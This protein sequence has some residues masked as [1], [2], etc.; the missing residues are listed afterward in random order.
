MMQRAEEARRVMQEKAFKSYR[1]ATEDDVR[2][3]HNY[4]REA[5]FISLESMSVVKIMEGSTYMRLYLTLAQILQIAPCDIRLWSIDSVEK[6]CNQRVNKQLSLEELQ[7]C[8][9]EHNKFY[10]EDLFGECHLSHNNHPHLN[11]TVTVAIHVNITVLN[12]SSTLVV[13]LHS[14]ISLHSIYVIK[15]SIHSQLFCSS[16]AFPPHSS[17]LRPLYSPFLSPSP[18]IVTLPQSSPLSSMYPTH[19]STPSPFLLQALISRSLTRP[20]H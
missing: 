13:V 2:G 17:F 10:V 8:D 6:T 3:F 20:S 7:D 18:P 9:I 19:P 14:I 5:D 4:R 12:S 11:H 16:F 15:Q 1:Y